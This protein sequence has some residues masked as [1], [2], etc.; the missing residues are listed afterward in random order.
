MK[1]QVREKTSQ[2]IAR[3][4]RAVPPK[5]FDPLGHRKARD[6]KVRKRLHTRAVVKTETRIQEWR[7]P[8][9]S[10]IRQ[11]ILSGNDRK[12]TGPSWYHLWKCQRYWTIIRTLKNRSLKRFSILDTAENLEKSNIQGVGIHVVNLNKTQWLDASCARRQVKTLW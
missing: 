7:P 2:D 3:R 12:F 8:R 11:A 10:V 1:Q 9:I 6:E 4:R 5:I